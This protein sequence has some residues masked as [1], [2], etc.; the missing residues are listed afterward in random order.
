MRPGLLL[1]VAD[2]AR[3]GER[4]GVPGARRGLLAVGA[5]DLAQAVERLGLAGLVADLL[6]QGQ[7]LLIAAAPP[8]AALPQVQVAEVCQ[9]PGLPGKVARLAGQ[10]QGIAEVDGRPGIAGLTHFDQAEVIERVHL[11]A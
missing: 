8:V 3:Q 9:R 11:A 5:E 6:E 4:G 7:R 10:G 2:L 1:L